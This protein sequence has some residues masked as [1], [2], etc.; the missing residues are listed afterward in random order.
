MIK[1]AS[2][3]VESEST[4]ELFFFRRIVFIGKAN[5]S[6]FPFDFKFTKS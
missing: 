5:G 3:T 2:T 4:S 6:K 1:R